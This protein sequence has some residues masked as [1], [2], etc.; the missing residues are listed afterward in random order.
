MPSAKSSLDS[1]NDRYIDEDALNQ[2]LAQQRTESLLSER[3]NGHRE[4]DVSIYDNDSTVSPD[5]A[6]TRKSTDTRRSRPSV[7]Q[8]RRGVLKT[9]GTVEPVQQEVKVGDISYRPGATPVSL[10]PEIPTVDFGPTQAFN[11]AA[12]RRTVTNGNLLQPAHEMSESPERFTPGP[13]RESPPIAQRSSVAYTSNLATDSHERSPSRNLVTPEPQARSPLRSPA[14]ADSDNRRSVAWQPGAQVGAGSPGARQSITPEQFVQQRAAAN[15]IV[16]PIYAHGRQG[17][18]SPTPPAIPR[19]AG[20]DSPI[21]QQQRRQSS[22]GNDLPP[23]PQSRTAPTLMNA[24]GDYT[25]HLSARE[26]EQV[27]RATKTPLINMAGKPNKNVPPQGGGLIGA[28]EARERE[29]KEAKQGLS[30]QA[31][32]QAIAQRQ[33]HSQGQSYQHQRQ[34]SFQIPTPQFSMPGQF[35]T[36]PPQQV[37]AQQQYS[38]SPQQ[39]SQWAQYQQYPQQQYAQS[40]PQPWIP[41]AANQFGGAQ[42]ASPLLQQPLQYQGNY[43]QQGR[44]GQGQQQYYGPYFGNGQSGR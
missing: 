37:P 11:P 26:Q 20:G 27:A 15:R 3:Q 33:Q 38:W 9:V 39:Q 23:R 6:S 2:V 21:Q 31:I 25:A 22:Y 19:N 18:A 44:Y 1:L 5:Y 10:N 43:Q 16:T 28:I 40:Q 36:T 41:P 29:K 7:E 32:Q 35:P 24:S 14:A 30:G 13:G 4:D 17:S 42:P 12:S 8:P 34:Q